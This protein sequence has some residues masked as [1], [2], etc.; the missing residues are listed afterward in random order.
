MGV[1]NLTKLL[2]RYAPNS[3]K[4]KPINDYQNKTLV[5]DGSIFL[6][7]FVYGFSMDKE[8]SHPHIHG[9]YKLTIF[10]K[11][12][13]I[14]SIF[15]FDGNKRRKEKRKENARRRL[16]TEKLLQ[17]WEFEKNRKDRA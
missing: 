8:I 14:K 11:Q 7:K 17:N 1:K 15:I 12:N 10:L 5:L 6:R 16:L 13:N 2:Q 3:I 9:F 4:P